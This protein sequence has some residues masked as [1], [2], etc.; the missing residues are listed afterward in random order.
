[1]TVALAWLTVFRRTLLAGAALGLA[2][3]FAFVLSAEST[4]RVTSPGD[5]ASGASLPVPLVDSA[6]RASGAPI[7]QAEATQPRDGLSG[8]GLAPQAKAVGDLRLART[9][10]IS[11]TGGAVVGGWEK[12]HG[13]GSPAVPRA[14]LVPRGSPVTLVRDEQNV[15]LAIIEA[16]REFGQDPAVMLCVARAESTLRVNVLGLSGERG[17]MQF[18]PATWGSYVR[19]A[20]GTARWTGNSARLGYGEQDVWLAIPAARVAAA[21]W[22]EGQAYQWHT[23]PGC[24]R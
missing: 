1:M 16:A 5:A 8:Q 6:V 20:D 14:L 3:P 17:P 24:A 18:M 4:S 12:A 2:I 10:S 19:E 21:M 11:P 7:P 13:A 9:T 23:W 22:S 15:E